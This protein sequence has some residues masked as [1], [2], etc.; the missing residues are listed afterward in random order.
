M[1]FYVRQDVEDKD[2][3]DFFKLPANVDPTETKVEEKSSKK[4]KGC[5][6]S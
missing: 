6:I 4:K 2:V 5:C 1:L 3:K